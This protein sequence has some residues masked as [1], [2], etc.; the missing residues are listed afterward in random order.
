MNKILLLFLSVLTVCSSNGQS[1]LVLNGGIMTMSNDVFLVVDNP[2]TNGITRNSGHII[3]EGQNNRLKWN[4]ANTTGTY[5]VPWGYGTSSYLPLTFT[6]AAGTGAGSFIFSTYHTSWLN[7]AALPAGVT[8]L[9][10]ATGDNSAYVVD[11]FWQINAQ[12]YTTKPALS[13][14]VMTYLDAEYTVASNAI[15]EAGL[16]AQR[17][18]STANSWSDMAATGTVNTTNNTV[19]IASISAANLYPWWVLVDQA[20]T[21]PLNFISFEAKKDE[22]IVNLKWTTTDEVNVSGFNIERSIDGH[23]FQSIGSMRSMGISG[24]NNYTSKDISPAAGLNFYRIKEIDQDG[25]FMYSVIRSIQMDGNAFV[26]VYPNPSTDYKV[27]VDLKKLPSD[28]YVVTVHDVSG[29]AI[30]SYQSQSG[31]RII[32]LDLNGKV[33]KGVYII[34]VTANNFA[35]QQKVFIL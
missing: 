11:R 25:K 4:I 8:G 15:S 27:Y 2:A 23:N 17:W 7:S 10:G 34:N 14:V 9:N 32:P 22:N 12:D 21:L 29:H 20:S 13:N 31:Q 28:K 33:R 1:R 26:S 3:S 18:N 19:T 24:L 6:K 16:K 30:Y 5:I 35:A